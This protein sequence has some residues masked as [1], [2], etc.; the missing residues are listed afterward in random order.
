MSI[1]DI[2]RTLHCLLLD[3]YCHAGL[4]SPL[5]GTSFGQNDSETPTEELNGLNGSPGLVVWRLHS[6][7]W[8]LVQGLFWAVSG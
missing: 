8:I 3:S 6:H 2:H 1:I 4:V 5:L 7:V